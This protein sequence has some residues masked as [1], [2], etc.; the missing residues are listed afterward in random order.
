MMKNFLIGAAALVFSVTAQAQTPAPWSPTPTVP[1]A[2][3]YCWDT[4]ALAY[5][6]CGSGHTGGTAAIT[7]TVTSNDGGTKTTAAAMPA[8]G[9]GLTG[10]LSA[11][12]YEWSQGLAAGGKVIG[13]V[14]APY[15]AI[16]STLTTPAGVTYT[17]ATTAAPLAICAAASVTPCAPLTVTISATPANSGWITRVVLQ[18]S[19]TGATSAQFRVVAFQTAPTLTGIYDATAYTV[20]AVD[21]LSRAFVGMWECAQANANLESFECSPDSPSGFNAFNVTAGTLYFAVE[22]IAPYVR[23]T[24]ETFTVLPDIA[25]TVP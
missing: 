18:K 25:A 7:G 6:V 12:W 15:A 19:T 9:V 4:V 5:A 14:G 8:G 20:P 11:I 2:L 23:A 10:W 1:S 21:M 16:S 3:S 13:G 22:A 17:G 24:G